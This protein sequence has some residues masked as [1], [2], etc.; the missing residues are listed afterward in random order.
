MGRIQPNALCFCPA[1]SLTEIIH[2]D[3]RHSVQRTHCSPD[4][5]RIIN[6]C[7]F[8]AHNDPRYAGSFRCPH[9]GAEITRILDILK[10]QQQCIRLL[11]NSVQTVLLLS[12][13]RHNSLRC[14]CIGNLS[15]Y[16]IIHDQCL[17]KIQS[18]KFRRMP[19]KALRYINPL[20]S[21]RRSFC[22][23]PDALCHKTLFLSSLLTLIQKLFD[24]FH[25]WIG[26]TCDHLLLLQKKSCRLFPMAQSH[27]GIF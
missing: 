18:P 21:V 6:I 14:L 1:D 17:R 15:E 12:D 9:H 3:K 26:N 27:C 23:H 4:G 19:V 5:L 25:L 24:P 20:Q 7:R 2:I 11:H 10:E 16:L 13:N 22:N 8:T